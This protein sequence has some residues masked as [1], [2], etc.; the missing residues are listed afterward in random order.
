[1]SNASHSIAPYLTYSTP[2]QCLRNFSA[3]PPVVWPLQRIYFIRCCVPPPVGAHGAWKNPLSRYRE[4]M[5]CFH[6]SLDTRAVGTIVCPQCGTRRVVKLHR[7]YPQVLALV[8]EKCAAIT[9]RCWAVFQ[10]FFDL[11]CHL[12][13]AIQGRVRLLPIHSR[14][15][16][17]CPRGN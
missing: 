1:M 9:C 4:H 5:E 2:Q 11:R 7:Q 13:K 10:A 12:R 17:I 8:G 6:I 15:R 16:G 14:R 3:L